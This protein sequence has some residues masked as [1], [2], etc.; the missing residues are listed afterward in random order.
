MYTITGNKCQP[1]KFSAT[2]G[3]K[4][5]C[6]DC[7]A[8][9]LAEHESSHNCT[10]SEKGAIVLGGGATSV[11][12]PAGSYKTDC[13]DTNNEQTCT[14]FEQCP[15]GW[16]GHAPANMSCAKCEKGYSSTV[17]TPKDGCRTCAKGKFSDIEGLKACNN[18]PISRFQPQDV[19]PSTACIACPT[20][21]KQ[22]QEGQSFCEDPGGI[23]PTNCG[24]D[25][26]WVPDKFPDKKLQ[27][28]CQ[29]CPDGGSCIGAIGKEGIRALFGWSKCPNVN[30]TYSQCKFGAACNGAANAVLKGKFID[31]TKDDFDP[32][33]HDQNE[34]CSFAYKNN[35]FLCSACADNFSHSGLG[36][37]CDAC[38]TPAANSAI[39][40]AGVVAGIGGLFVYVLITLSDEGKIDPA[41]GAKTIGLSYV[42]I[43]SLL[44]TFPIAWP[45]IFVSIFRVGGA[46]GKR[47]CCC[48]WWCWWCWWC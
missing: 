38:P 39:A 47:C 21:Y 28:G 14:A 12:V 16:M 32:A 46:V 36:N 2:P 7:K 45:D 6:E 24:D 44:T 25:E 48:C 43:I 20:G 35:S 3:N 33:M 31:D 4:K 1:G 40:V 5:G 42:Q 17:G 30:L 27:A 26:Y 11:P 23:K 15:A 34:S 13:S 29:D 41:D 18:C 8:G 37:K 19:S 22:D 9:Q 10:M